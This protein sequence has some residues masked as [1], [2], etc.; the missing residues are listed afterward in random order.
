VRRTILQTLAL[1]LAMSFVVGVIFSFDHLEALPINT[2]VSFMYGVVM[3]LPAMLLFRWLRP[4]LYGRPQL[5]QWLIYVGTLAAIVVVGTLLVRAILVA[6]GLMSVDQMWSGMIASF[7][8]SVAI[9]IPGTIG[10][11][12]YSKLQRQL[13]DREADVQRAL[14]V[15]TEARLASLESRTRPHFLFNALNS[16]IALIPEHP[17]RAERLLERLCALLRFSL[18]AQ[19]SLVPLEQELRVAIDYLEI[20]R[21]RFGERLAYEIDVPDELRSIAVPAFALQTLVE[22]SVKY[23]VSPRK[24]GGRIIVRARRS[25]DRLVLDV[26][27]DGPGFASESWLVGHGLDVLRS[28]LDALYGA[29]AKL[30]APAACSG[31]AAVSVEVPLR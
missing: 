28:R 8:I 3:G 23:A 31:G 5:R 26:V 16:A 14:A 1:A 22:N 15:A 11:V 12:T 20:E 24:H 18:D 9:G 2:L 30:V 17:E 6:C 29:A 19:L 25:D 4:R 7:E 27:D 10:A 13:S 21:V